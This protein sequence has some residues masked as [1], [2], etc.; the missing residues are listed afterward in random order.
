M[1][2]GFVECCRYVYMPTFLAWLNVKAMAHAR[3]YPEVLSLEDVHGV[4][5]FGDFDTYVTLPIFGFSS[6]EVRTCRRGFACIIRS[7]AW[8]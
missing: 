4:K 5:T 6:K 7:I 1:G 8:W 3:A 2:R